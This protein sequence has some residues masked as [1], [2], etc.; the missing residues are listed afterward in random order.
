[1]ATSSGSSKT[2]VQLSP[3]CSQ[4]RQS[5]PRLRIAIAEVGQSSLT[6]SRSAAPPAVRPPMLIGSRSNPVT[7]SAGAT[8][9]SIATDSA[10]ELSIAAALLALSATDA[11]VPSHQL[12]RPAARQG[13]D[14]HGDYALAAAANRR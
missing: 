14:L 5:G 10:P 12:R 9:V 2:A 7:D 6:N 4:P 11:S 1:M 8:G 3:A 13:S